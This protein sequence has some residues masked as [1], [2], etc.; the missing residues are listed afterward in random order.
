MYGT[1]AGSNPAL[2]TSYSLA[3]VGLHSKWDGCEA[4]W[5]CRCSP[6]APEVTV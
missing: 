6:H 5:N 3:G 4:H 2:H 1:V